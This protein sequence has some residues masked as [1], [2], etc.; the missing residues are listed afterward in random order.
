MLNE[1]TL[2]YI[3][4]FC[5]SMEDSCRLLIALNIKPYGVYCN[6]LRHVFIKPT[7][8]T[9]SYRKFH[10]YVFKPSGKMSSLCGYRIVDTRYTRVHPVIFK[11]NALEITNV[12]IGK[13][14]HLTLKD[15]TGFFH[16]RMNGFIHHFCLVNNYIETQFKTSFM[17]DKI[18][19][20]TPIL[21]SSFGNPNL[22]QTIFVIVTFSI[23]FDPIEELFSPC[24]SSYRF[25]SR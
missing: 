23:C 12:Q 7:L 11:S 13:K 20:S 4:Y 6:L 24:P 2:T 16:L 17:D 9:W 14:Y 1:D 19:V 3:F 8:T 25:L 15:P 21:H 18:I 5:H 10:R 22:S